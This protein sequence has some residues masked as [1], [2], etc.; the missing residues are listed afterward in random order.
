M[1]GRCGSEMAQGCVCLCLPPG[2]ETAVT[3]QLEVS[4]QL[5]GCGL[6]VY[7]SGGGLIQGQ[8]VSL[9]T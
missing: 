3:W 6:G 5:V 1:G 8:R 2:G 9:L 4:L 7:F